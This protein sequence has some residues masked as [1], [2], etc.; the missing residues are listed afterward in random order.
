MP[1]HPLLSSILVFHHPI[2]KLTL[3]FIS[4]IGGKGQMGDTTVMFTA[5]LLGYQVFVLE[6]FPF[7]PKNPL[8]TD[9]ENFE[10]KEILP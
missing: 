7:H 2:S 6:G 3:L 1:L 5:A 9:L 10:G 8:Q 4:V